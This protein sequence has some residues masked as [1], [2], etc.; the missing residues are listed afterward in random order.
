MSFVLRSLHAPLKTS[1]IN[2][3]KKP[4]T[5]HI[6]HTY[7]NTPANS[8]KTFHIHSNQL[9]QLLSLSYYT[10]SPDYSSF[11]YLVCTATWS[12]SIMTEDPTCV[13]HAYICRRAHSPSVFLSMSILINVNILRGLLCRL[14]SLCLKLTNEASPFVNGD[15]TEL[16][17]R[18]ELF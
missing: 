4:H 13:N 12:T 8:W 10:S 14:N 17:K 15:W 16:I 9:L 2:K 7:T 5:S 18:C 11:V 6:L 3:K 1:D